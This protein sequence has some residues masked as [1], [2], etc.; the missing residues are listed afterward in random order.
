LK[1]FIVNP[2]ATN[3]DSEMPSYDGIPA[4]DLDALVA[5]LRTLR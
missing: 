1:A 3:P 4:N 2:A 5:Y